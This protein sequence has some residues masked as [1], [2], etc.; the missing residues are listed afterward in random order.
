MK[1]ALAL[2]QEARRIGVVGDLAAV[3][4]AIAS[5]NIARIRE[6]VLSSTEFFNELWSL[7]SQLRI[8]QGDR[9]DGHMRRAP[10]RGNALLVV[11]SDTGLIGDIDERIIAAAQPHYRQGI[12]IIAVGEHGAQLLR[13]RSMPPTYTFKLPDVDRSETALMP[14]NSLVTSYQSVTVLYQTYVSFTHQEVA[15]IELFSAVA[16]LGAEQSATSAITSTQYIFEPSLSE[17]VTYMESIMIGIALGQVILES[18]LAQ[19]ASRFNAMTAAKTKSKDMQEQLTLTLHRALRA[20]AD[21]QTRDVLNAMAII[22][23]SS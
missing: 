6:Q 19:Y 7:Y 15:T 18:K 11:T 10:T 2:Q 3:F 20:D 9:L 1:R 8:R 5:T 4:E 14:L 13:Q 12:D 17:I 16:A 22:G 23:R 21:E